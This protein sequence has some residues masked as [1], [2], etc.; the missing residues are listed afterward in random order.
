MK[1]QIEKLKADLREFIEL[2]KTITPAKWV[3]GDKGDMVYRQ[4][5]QLGQAAGIIIDGRSSGISREQDQRD[6]AFIA[7]SRNI[8][9]AMAECLLVAVEEIET[10]REEVAHWKANHDNQA[11]IKAALTQRPDLGDRASRVQQLIKESAAMRE[12]IREAI[13]AINRLTA[14]TTEDMQH[15]KAKQDAIRFGIA[16]LSK[17]HFFITNVSQPSEE[18][19]KA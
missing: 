14:A 17:L 13:T 6:A 8:L 4:P 16:T 3:T 12:A 2:S 15:A 18:H 19:N 5:G 9:P 10:M 1:E 11:K 7:R